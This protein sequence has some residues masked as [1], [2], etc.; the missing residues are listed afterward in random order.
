MWSN[1]KM[2]RGLQLSDDSAV[3]NAHACTSGNASTL[4]QIPNT[5]SQI[6]TKY[7]IQNTKFT[8]TNTKHT[9]PNTQSQ[10]PNTQSQIPNT[11]TQLG[12]S[13]YGEV[14]QNKQI[15][16]LKIS[17]YTPIFVSTSSG[18]TFSVTH[19][20]R[21]ASIPKLGWIFGKL[22]TSNGPCVY[23]IFPT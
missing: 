15:S 4:S 23:S 18:P 13:Q 5:Q 9:I 22:P 11:Q 20:I 1:D 10:I 14:F 19:W 2:E 12:S 17:S 7:T 21:D 8:I 6:C 3:P 16:W